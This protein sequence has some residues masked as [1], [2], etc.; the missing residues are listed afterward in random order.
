LKRLDANLVVTV[1][2][3]IDP[4]EFGPQPE[5]VRIERYVPQALLL[6]HVDLVVSHGGSGSV[7]GALEHGRPMVIAPMGADQ[8]LNAARCA[9]LGLGR[10]L[11]AERATPEDV[12]AA[13]AE[14][15]ADPACR[16]AAERMRDEIAALPGPSHA[17]ALLEALRP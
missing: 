2:Q 13:A 8:P 3:H 17:V 16:A 1:G 15:L 4:A 5:T 7:M 10:V 9:A 14:V 11:D 6:P 12:H